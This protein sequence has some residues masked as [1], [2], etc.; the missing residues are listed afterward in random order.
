MTSA[1][2]R[3]FV[4]GTLLAGERDH[5]LVRDS[6]PLGPAITRPLFSLFEAGVYAAMVPGGS[7]AVRGEIYL[8]TRET[9]IA[10]DVAREVPLLFQRTRVGLDDAT[11]AEAYVM[12][13]ELVR[14]QRRLHHGNWLERFRP[15]VQRQPSAWS[16]WARDRQKKR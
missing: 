9:L 8:V 16:A 1:P 3:L 12:P 11:E 5:A 4:Y 7:T 14:G 13:R 2:I 15:N 6:E 10:I